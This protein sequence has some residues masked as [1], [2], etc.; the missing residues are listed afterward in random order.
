MYVCMYVY[1]LRNF[2][3][4]NYKVFSM[5]VYNVHICTFLAFCDNACIRLSVDLCMYV[6]MNTVTAGS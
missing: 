6:C 1:V 5:Y 3:L 2:A 4:E